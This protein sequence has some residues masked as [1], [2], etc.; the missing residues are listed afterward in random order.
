MLPR[1]PLEKRFR[2]QH[3][4]ALTRPTGEE[5]KIQWWS[6]AALLSPVNWPPRRSA[7]LKTKLRAGLLFCA[8]E[9]AD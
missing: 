9:S 1:R 3:H 4:V 2:D 8:D 7:E 5:E 6:M